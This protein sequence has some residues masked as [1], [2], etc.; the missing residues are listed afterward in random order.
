MDYAFLVTS[1]KPTRITVSNQSG[2]N[3]DVNMASPQYFLKQSIRPGQSVAL[4]GTAF[5]DWSSIP[6]NNFNG[7]RDDVYVSI[8]N[9]QGDNAGLFSALND[10]SPATFYLNGE[11]QDDTGTFKFASWEFNNGDADGFKNW[12]ITVR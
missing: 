1:I 8:W 11:S 3:V 5:A 10:L 2:Q 4:S 9:S 7:G 6:F 12:T